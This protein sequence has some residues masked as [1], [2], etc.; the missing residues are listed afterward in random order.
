METRRV[1]MKS[2]YHTI[3]IRLGILVLL[4]IAFIGMQKILPLRAES[5]N[6]NAFAQVQRLRDAMIE[7]LRNNNLSQARR[8]AAIIMAYINHRE[9]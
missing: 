2:V 1:V 7:E 4:G 8:L 6:M 5:A 9:D 3:H